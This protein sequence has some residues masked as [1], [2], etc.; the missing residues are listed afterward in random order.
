MSTMELPL[1]KENLIAALNAGAV[2]AQTMQKTLVFAAVRAGENTSLAQVF[3][4]HHETTDADRAI[5][6][7]AVFVN[8]AND[9]YSPPDPKNPWKFED[10][11]D[12]SKGAA[13][14]YE[15]VAG[16]PTGEKAMW[17]VATQSAEIVSADQIKQHLG[18]GAFNIMIGQTMRHAREGAVLRIKRDANGDITDFGVIDGEAYAESWGPV[19]SDPI[20]P[21][22]S[23]SDMANIEG[24]IGRQVFDDNQLTAAIKSGGGKL[25][26]QPEGGFKVVPA[27]PTGNG[28]KLDVRP[29]S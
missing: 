25:Q 21:S 1:K 7:A 27:N 16:D 2:T 17:I 10:L 11:C 28:T 6:G 5:Q 23:A 9:V 20:L 3:S 15:R 4:G 14:A 13:G 18:T 29:T 8:K 26:R 12:Q 19:G 24:R 22:W